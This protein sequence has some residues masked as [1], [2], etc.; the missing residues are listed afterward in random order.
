MSDLIN[1]KYLSKERLE[2][3][4]FLETFNFFK[5]SPKF[6][7]KYDT[8]FEVYEK[9]FKNYRKKKITFVEVGVA[10]GGSLFI[11]K[12]FFHEDSRII[13]I[14]LNPEAKNL[15]KYGFEIFIGNQSDKKFWDDF[16]NRVG[17]I[18]IILDDG[19]HKNIQQISTVDNSINNINEDGL[20][21]VED[22]HSSFIKWYYNPSKYSFINF[23]NLII[24]SIN[25]RCL[26]LNHKKQ[27]AYSKKVYAIEFFESIVVLKISQIKSRKSSMI[28]NDA[29]DEYFL[30]FRNNEYFGVIRNFTEEKLKYLNQIKIFKK[31]LRKIF[32]RNMLF[33]LLENKKI[34]KI[35]KKS[36]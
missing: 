2:E 3:L 15:E 16:Y 11:W 36:Y 21:V 5:N 28:F 6:S 18:D 24:D 1:Y 9:I 17:N 33:N 27:N 19:G 12:K 22:V 8:Y 23:T 30:D 20:I 29:K 26:H 13:G 4:N 32:Y 31:I 35:K 10:N 14:D 34:K 7:I 25:R